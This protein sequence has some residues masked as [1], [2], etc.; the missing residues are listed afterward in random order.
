MNGILPSFLGVLAVILAGYQV[1]TQLFEL[2]PGFFNYVNMS[3]DMDTS[4]DLGWY[5]P[6]SSRINSIESAINSTGTYGF[7]FNSS[8]LPEGVPYGIVSLLTLSQLG[9]LY[10]HRHV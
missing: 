1:L 9:S 10:S 6:L 2:T 8:T 3:P 5:A 7:I 4:I